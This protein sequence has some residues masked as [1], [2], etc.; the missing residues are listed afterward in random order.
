M[1]GLRDAM[2]IACES[3]LAMRDADADADARS[4]LDD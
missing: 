3:R 2:H 1:R 4:P